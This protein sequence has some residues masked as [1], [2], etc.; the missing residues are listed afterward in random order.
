MKKLVAILQ[1]SYYVA[2]G[3]WPLLDMASFEAVAGPKTDD[4]LV[5]T[6]GVLVT[7]IGTVLL[8]A[9]LKAQ[10]D[11]PIRVLA[12]ASA[13]GLAGID[14][15]YAM[16][17]VIWAIYML[18]G[19]GEVVLVVLWLLAISRDRAPTPTRVRQRPTP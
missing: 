18:D 17:G 2:T 7:V 3:L 5:T 16:R 14:F 10:V 8:Y 6:V 11:G 19:V 15:F 4:W 9:G 13:A 1:G 12:I